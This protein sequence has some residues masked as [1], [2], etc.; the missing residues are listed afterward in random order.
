MTHTYTDRFYI[1][2]TNDSTGPVVRWKSN[3]SVPPKDVLKEFLSLGLIDGTIFE[4]S[5]SARSAE[6]SKF[7]Q[8]Y[9]DNYRG[10]SQEELLEARAAFGAGTRVVN[11]I[12]GTSY[13]V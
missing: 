3:D 4:N 8:D 10:P 11:V 13:V 1:D 12:T 6:L 2:E 9:R 7:L 5:N